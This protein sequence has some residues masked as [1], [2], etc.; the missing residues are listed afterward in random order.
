MVVGLNAKYG[1]G[2]VFALLSI[3]LL[4]GCG[5]SKPNSSVNATSNKTA[6]QSG[7]QQILPT[8]AGLKSITSP[9]QNGNMYLLAGNSASKGLYQMELSDGKITNSVSV[10]NNAVDVAET[11]SGILAMGQATA[12]TGAVE[13]FDPSTLKLQRTIPIGAPVLG[14]TTDQR[15]GNLVY[16]LNGN[17]HSESVSVVN[18]GTGQVT[19]NIPVSL[20]TVGIA[21]DGSTLYGLENNG[22]IEGFTVSNAKPAFQFKAVDSPI[23]LTLSP[24]GQTLYILR[25]ID[26]GTNVSVFN[27]QTESQTRAVGAPKDATFLAINADGTLLYVGV[28]TSTSSNVQA[29]SV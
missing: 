20:G 4:A 16:V 23:A 17:S 15:D 19:S 14:I 3:S 8:P 10:S 24:D 25:A 1:V 2:M 9:D 28:R 5:N 18:V 13:V 29:L 12:T 26:N 6:L 11:P 22:D 27:L 21:T 7:V